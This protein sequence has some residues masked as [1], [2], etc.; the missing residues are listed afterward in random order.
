MHEGGVEGDKGRYGLGRVEF[1]FQQ[2]LSPLGNSD[3]S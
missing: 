1:R 2:S 3:I